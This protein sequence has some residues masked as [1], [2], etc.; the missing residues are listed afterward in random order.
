LSRDQYS[1]IRRDGG[2]VARVGARYLRA[3]V[4]RKSPHIALVPV[5]HST[6]TAPSFTVTV[7]PTSVKDAPLPI[8]MKMPKPFTTIVA[9]RALF[10]ATSFCVMRAISSDV[11]PISFGHG[12]ERLSL[13]HLAGDV[14]PASR[15]E[16]SPIW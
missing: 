7:G 16:V 6:V 12:L 4:D 3:E 14:V 8:E 5:G 9:P 10:A 2:G 11:Q 15:S 13:L 1:W